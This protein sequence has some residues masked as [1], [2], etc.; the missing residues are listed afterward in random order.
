[1]QDQADADL[2]H[3]VTIATSIFIRIQLTRFDQTAALTYSLF[4]VTT[5]A[6]TL[7]AN[8]GASL[9]I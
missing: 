4:D 6:S 7:N 2:F 5:P 1:M 9:A 8:D 3:Q